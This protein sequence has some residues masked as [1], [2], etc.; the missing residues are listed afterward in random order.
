MPF[1]PTHH[2]ARAADA[3]DISALANNCNLTHGQYP[4]NRQKDSSR[5]F[6]EFSSQRNPQQCS[7][8]LL[9]KIG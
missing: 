7:V 4:Q 8:T 2:T 6:L 1:L 3:A 5:L 9:I